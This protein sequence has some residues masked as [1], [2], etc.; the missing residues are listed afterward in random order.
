MA[1]TSKLIDALRPDSKALLVMARRREQVQV[2]E[3]GA[4][5]GIAELATEF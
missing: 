2:C 1:L 5:Q 4:W 3:H